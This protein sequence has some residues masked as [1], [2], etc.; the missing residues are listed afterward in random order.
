MDVGQDFPMVASGGMGSDN[1]TVESWNENSLYSL[2]KKQCIVLSGK[3]FL[4]T[5]SQ[6][7]RASAS[8]VKALLDNSPCNPAFTSP[9]PFEWMP[10]DNRLFIEFR[11]GSPFVTVKGIIIEWDDKSI[12][13]LFTV[14]CFCDYWNRWNT[15]SITATGGKSKFEIMFPPD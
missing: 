2:S 11:F 10:N 5:C 4:H 15:V 3:M 8:S 9:K 6:R 12:P 14:Q 7:M 1:T 13:I